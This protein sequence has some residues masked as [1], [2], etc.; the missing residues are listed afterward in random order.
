MEK[1]KLKDLIPIR[2]VREEVN[3][4]MFNSPLFS[5]NDMKLHNDIMGAIENV[6]VQL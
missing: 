1:L 6:E 2:E 3:L 4:I 5:V